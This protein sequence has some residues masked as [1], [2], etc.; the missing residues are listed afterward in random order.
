M[1]PVIGLQFKVTALVP[2]HEY[3]Y[4]IFAENAAGISVPSSSSPFYKATDTLFQPGPPGNPRILDTTKSSITIAWNKPVYDGGSEITGY[5]IEVSIVSGLT[6]G[7]QYMFRVSA[8]NEKGSSDPRQIGVPVIAKDLVI[9][10]SVKLL[11][12]TFSVIAGEDLSID[13]PFNARPKATVS[14]AKDGAP[15][16]RTTRTNFSSSEKMLN[17]SIKEACRDDVGH[18]VIKLS[19][20]A[21]ETTADIGVIVL[22]K[23]GPPSGPVKVEEV[24]A[25]S[26]TISWKTPEYDGGCPINNYI[27]EKRDTST[28]VWQIVA[29]NL[30]R[31]K[32]KAGRLKTGSEYQFR[33]TA[34]NRYGKSPLLVSECVDAQYPF[35]VPGPPGTPFIQSSTKDSMVVVWNEP[36]N[37]GGSSVVGYH[38]ERKERNSI[39]WIKLNKSLI[40]DTTF[41]TTGLEGG[42]EYE[43]RVYAEN[44][45]GIGKASKVSEGHVARDPCDPPG[46]PETIVVNAGDTF[47][48][49]ADV[50]GKP[51]PTIH[52]IKGEQEL[53][54]TIHRE[55]KNSDST[56]CLIVKEAKLTDGGTYTLLL[57]NAGGE[58]SVNVKICVLD[59]PGP[60]EGPIFVTGVTSEQCCLTWKP[61][62]QDGGSIISHYIVER[63]ETSRLIWTVVDP[64]VQTTV[65]KIKKLLE[66]N[67]YIFR[68]LAV[69]KFGV[70]ESLQS[71]AVLIKDPFIPPDAPKGVDVSNIKKDSMVITWEP[72]TNDGGSPVTG[73]IIEKHDKE[74]V[75]WTRCNRSTVTDVTYK[76]KGLLEGHAYEFRVAAENA[77]GTGEPSSPSVYF[78]AFDPVF[79]PG[80]PS[81]PKVTD[82]NKTSVMLAWGKPIFDG[83]SEIQGYID[84]KKSE[85]KEEEK[86]EQ[87][88]ICTPPTGVKQ[89]RFTVENL[90]E[91]QAYKFRICAINKVG[92]GE[93]VDVP[94][95][96]TPEDKTEEPDLDID[97]ELQ[98]VVSIKAGASLRVFIPIKGRPSPAIT[99]A[100]DEG[101]LKETAQTEVTSTYTSLVIDSVTRLDSG[102]YTVTAE[103]STGTK[104]AVIVV[105]VLDTPSAPINLKVQEITKESVTLSWEPPLM[106]GGAHVKNYII[107]KRE[108][109]RKTYSAVVTNCHKLSW[110]IEPLQEG[111]NYYFR[112]LAENMHGIGL[113][114]ETVD[115]LKVS[116]VPQTPGKITVVD[117]TKSSVSLT[118]EKPI[119]DGGSRIIQ[120][121]VE[122][123][124]KGN[125]KWSGC[126]NVKTLEAVVK[127]LNP[128]EEY[129][130]RVIAINEKGKSDPRTLAVP[131]QAKDL[132]I[133]P[134]I[135]PAFSNY[136]VLVGKDLTV[137]IPVV[138]RPAPKVTWTKDGSA[139]KITSRINIVNTPHLT[140]INIKEAASEDGGMYGISVSNA[141][142]QRDATIE[143]ITLDKPGPP[144]GPVRFD[145]ITLQS[146]TISWDP[147]KHSGGCSVSNY[148]VQKRDT[149]S[150]TWENVALSVN[151][152][153]TI[154]KPSYNS[155]PITAM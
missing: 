76:V 37:D 34:E 95:P 85:E 131:I 140:T 80:P 101:P 127:N 88:T 6:P 77:V 52:W 143:I 134:E 70:G 29:S 110:K 84:E 55:I 18:Y 112:V 125:E 56:A 105:R 27:V 59:K 138:G 16:K 142:G 8:K 90:K 39:L 83:A 149:T 92:V 113:P 118:W 72:P 146:I 152:A 107:E 116:E 144:V 23:P 102:K 17:L 75:R 30:A 43:F 45:V 64:K 147:P 98:K 67:E 15:L 120:Y 153:G 154:S 115:P 26:I 66:G 111:C 122:M 91:K 81:N 117:V 87:W 141:V 32:I 40:Q 19:N 49:D 62:L 73:Y 132:V 7:E 5:I 1:K 35:K 82:M 109:T 69:N 139:L 4:R 100:K 38:L 121:L 151:A 123:Q 14:W 63:R 89:T 136:S 3:E 36:V 61:P 130:F 137:E 31:T 119:H 135:K 21:G 104:S 47:K 60:P 50:H 48:I 13:V 65:L 78:K 54:N 97:P 79:R 150:A 10:P 42:V 86:T 114:A 155:G 148:I 22:D 12:S 96:I 93:H 129:I 145:E 58:K 133:E 53:S 51:T 106:D 44:I 128:G 124:V 126:A 28:N 94:G 11:F 33:I 74:G 46:T 108:S 9:A 99:W 71:E 103:N 68:V 24:T 2:G 20:S 25:D 57:R 41:K